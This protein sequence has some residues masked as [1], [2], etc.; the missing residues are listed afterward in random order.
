L[1]RLADKGDF[2]GV[3]TAI[4][5]GT[6]G[7]EDRV[8]QYR[9]ALRVIPERIEEPQVIL[10]GKRLENPQAL[11]HG[12]HVNSVNPA[13]L[14][15]RFSPPQFDIADRISASQMA[16]VPLGRQVIADG[17]NITGRRMIGVEW[18]VNASDPMNVYIRKRV[19]SN[20][21]AQARAGTRP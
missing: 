2:V 3:T 9:A 11:L 20:D 5:G 12:V 18:I 19:Y 4:N 8:R 10:E 14:H 6:N 1:N 7:L 15:I 13:A 17:I 21:V 16:R